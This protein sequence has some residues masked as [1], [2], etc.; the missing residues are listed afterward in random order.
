LATARHLARTTRRQARRPDSAGGRER[1]RP[2]PQQLWREHLTIGVPRHRAGA[3]WRDRPLRRADGH[4]QDQARHRHRAGEPVLR[5][6]LRHLPRRGRHPDEGRDAHRLRAGS[7]R[8]LSEAVPRHGRR[9]RRRPAR[10][11]QRAARRQQWGHGRVHRAGHQRQEGL[12]RQCEHRRQPGLLQLGVTRR[13][14]LP[15]RGRNPEL[16]DLRTGLRARRPHVRTGEVVVAARPPVPRVGLVGEVLEPRAVELSERDPWPLHARAD[17]AVRGP[18]HQQRDGRHHQRVDRHHLAALQQARPLGLLRPNGRP[19]RLRRRLGGQLPPGGP[20]L[21][22]ARYL[23]PAACLRGRAEGPPAAQHPTAQ[24]LLRRSQEGRPAGGHVGHAL[25]SRQRA[26][27][28]ERAPRSGLRHRR[29]QRRHEEQGLGLDRHLLA[30]GRLGRLLRSR[31]PATG[32]PE[33]VR[34]AR[35]GH[36][37]LAVCQARLCRPPGPEQRRLP[38]VHRGRLPRRLPPQPQDRRPS[39]PAARR[40][41]GREDPRQHGPGLR[42]QPG[43]ARTGVAA[44]QSAD[45]FAHGSHLLHR[46][47]AV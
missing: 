35:A 23:E 45:G 22:D 18:S 12:W 26:S 21:S 30:V 24:Q 43:A 6:L 4:P 46:L 44:D 33:R 42:L 38:Q 3:R 20:E 14:G 17:A 19:A 16:L 36:G 7:L 8:R 11:A 5:Q 47:G 41:R 1:A 28:G 9:Q 25:A 32:R 29:H 39:R 34:A 27:A 37:D 13:D 2:R 10:R 15:H 31:H 40:A